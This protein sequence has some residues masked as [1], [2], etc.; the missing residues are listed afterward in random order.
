MIE[1]GHEDHSRG[2]KVAGLPRPASENRA[3]LQDKEKPP[4]LNKG[5]RLKIVEFGRY[6]PMLTE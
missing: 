1:N 3:V 6:Y 2:R 4:A 5:W